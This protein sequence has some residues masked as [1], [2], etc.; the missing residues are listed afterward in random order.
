MENPASNVAKN[1][2]PYMRMAYT[3]ASAEVKDQEI[4]IKVGEE[5]FDVQIK[6]Y[7][8]TFSSLYISNMPAMLVN[9]LNQCRPHRSNYTAETYHDNFTLQMLLLYHLNAALQ[10]PGKYHYI[11]FL[12]LRQST[13]D[14]F[15]DFIPLRLTMLSGY[16]PEYYFICYNVSSDPSL[17]YQKPANVISLRRT[18]IPDKRTSPGRRN[19]AK[20]LLSEFIRVKYP[21]GQNLIE[22]LVIP[23]CEL[24]LSLEKIVHLV[25][26]IVK[27]DKQEFDDFFKLNDVIPK[28]VFPIVNKQVKFDIPSSEP[29]HSLWKISMMYE[30]DIQQYERLKKVLELPMPGGFEDI[31]QLAWQIKQNAPTGWELIQQSRL[32]EQTPN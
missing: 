11:I 12:D 23:M 9:Y 8:R 30:L 29:L 13:I 25:H 16:G 31:K 18:E 14:K 26:G 5:E 20:L 7:K 28:L 27:F 24:E 4:H 17:E 15:K 10:T 6:N 19:A 32:A 22:E 21:N 3:N 1:I 2:A